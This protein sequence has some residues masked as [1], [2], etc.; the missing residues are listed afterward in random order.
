MS[1]RDLQALGRPESFDGPDGPLNFYRNGS[2]FPLVLLHSLA[3]SA[4]M[5]VDIVG[6]FTPAHD[7]IALDMR[8]HGRSGWSKRDFSI[9]DLAGDVIALLDH[10]GL[11]AADVLGLS[12]GGSVAL[13]LAGMAPERVRNLAL[14]DTTAWYGA[15]A[16]EAWAERAFQAANRARHLQ[17]GFQVERWYTDAF[18]RHRPEMVSTATGLF[19]STSPQ[20]HA[21]ASRALGALDSRFLLG[22]IT[23][24]TLVVC[25][26]EDRATTP[27]M[28]EAI[29]AQVKGA[30]LIM[31]PGRHF[32]IFESVGLRRAISAHLAGDSGSGAVSQADLHEICCRVPIQV[33]A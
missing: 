7:V 15:D 19:L 11:A 17:I 20:V 16:P 31:A 5:W 26:K 21:A 22:A 8:G 4:P 14:C 24:S 23:A 6:E 33:R 1:P 27:A 9:A 2:G 10:L 32:A 28:G 3:L 18:R 30:S 12:M 29:V 13:T 25:G